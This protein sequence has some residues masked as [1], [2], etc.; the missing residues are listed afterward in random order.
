MGSDLESQRCV[1]I[2]AILTIGGDS[3]FPKETAWFSMA[4][5]PLTL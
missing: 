4:T 3:P 1:I 2:L 5:Y